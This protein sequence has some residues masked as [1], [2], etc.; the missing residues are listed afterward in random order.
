MQSEFFQNLAKIEKDM[1]V[2]EILMLYDEHI[3]I[4]IATGLKTV[5]QAMITWLD[6]GLGDLRANKELVRDEVIRKF[7]EI[8]GGREQQQL[9]CTFSTNLSNKSA[10]G[11]KTKTNQKK[12]NMRQ[13]SKSRRNNCG[14]HDANRSANTS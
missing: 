2:T 14:A 9:S 1:T 13:K 12:E 6:Q 7:N 3:N 8:D 4:K 5:S 10:S 11:L